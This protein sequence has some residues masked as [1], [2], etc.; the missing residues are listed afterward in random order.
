MTEEKQKELFEAWMKENKPKLNNPLE[1]SATGKYK[2][3]S[4]Q[5]RYEGF[6]AALNIKENS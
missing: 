4:T 2:T 3:R 1:I 6:T 5:L